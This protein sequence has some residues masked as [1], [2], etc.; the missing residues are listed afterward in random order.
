MRLTRKA[1]AESSGIA[2]PLQAI[3]KYVRELPPQ[4][5]APFEITRP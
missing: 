2:S 5:V 4:R 1:N 3:R